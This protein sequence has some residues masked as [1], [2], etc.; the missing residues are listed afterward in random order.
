MYMIS[1]Y[2]HRYIS[3]KNEI[4]STNTTSTV[5]IT[6]VVDDARTAAEK[7]YKGLGGL[8]FDAIQYNGHLGTRL[9]LQYQGFQKLIW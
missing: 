2:I 5:I 1:M 9:L 4:T 3:A 7:C 8:L 6:S